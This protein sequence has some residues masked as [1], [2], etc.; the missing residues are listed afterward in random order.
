MD[1]DDEKPYS[2]LSLREQRRFSI[3]KAKLQKRKEEIETSLMIAEDERS[4]LENEAYRVR[5]YKK[6]LH[7]RPL[8]LLS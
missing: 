4:K 1:S 5:N 6:S 2:T 8:V 3:K 7:V